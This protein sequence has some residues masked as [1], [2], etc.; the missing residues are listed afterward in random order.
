MRE[1]EPIT[2]DIA[3]AIEAHGYEKIRVR[4]PLTCEAPLGVCARCYG[5]DLAAEP[6]GGA[7]P[8]GRHHRGPVD[9]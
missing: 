9:W 4:S 8:R 5:M 6:A 2:E 1:H 3:A 7:R